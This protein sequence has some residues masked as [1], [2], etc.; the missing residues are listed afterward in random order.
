MV[1][2]GA[3]YGGDMVL[4]WGAEAQLQHRSRNR[5]KA[6]QQ[7]ASGMGGGALVLGGVSIAN[8]C[9]I[10]GSV[11]VSLLQLGP[12]ALRLFPADPRRPPPESPDRAPLATPALEKQRDAKTPEG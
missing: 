11:R 2:H 9:W 3:V 5:P 8:D 4:G 6:Y 1:T 7:L 10:V 12:G